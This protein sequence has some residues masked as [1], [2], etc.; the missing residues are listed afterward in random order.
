MMLDYLVLFLA[1]SVHSKSYS[2]I[3]GFA[4]LMS[5]PAKSSPTHPTPD[6]GM[7]GISSFRSLFKCHI[8]RDLY[9]QN[10]HHILANLH[11]IPL[12]FT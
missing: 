4:L 11:P 10:S 8:L 3:R 12:P 7:A 6:L 2:S 5:P 9:Y 1:V